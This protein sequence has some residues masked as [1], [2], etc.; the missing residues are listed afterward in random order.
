MDQVERHV[1]EPACY[2]YVRL[3]IH[4]N[5]PAQFTCDCPFIAPSGTSSTKNYVSISTGHRVPFS[6]RQLST[7]F[8]RRK[9]DQ[10]RSLPSM[11]GTTRAN[12][13]IASHTDFLS[14]DD[15]NP[16]LKTECPVCLG[17]IEEHVCVKII[18]IP[19]CS[20]LIGL[21]CL[22]TLLN[23]NPNCRK[24]CPF[25]RTEWLPALF[26]QYGNLDAQTPSN[27][28]RRRREE[29]DREIRRM[30]EESDAAVGWSQEERENRRFLEQEE[31][32]LNVRESSALTG[33]AARGS[34]EQRRERAE[35]VAEMHRLMEDRDPIQEPSREGDQMLEENHET[36][37]NC[38]LGVYIDPY[39]I[40]GAQDGA[41]AGS[42]LFRREPAREDPSLQRCLYPEP[43]NFAFRPS[44]GDNGEAGSS[45]DRQSTASRHHASPSSSPPHRQEPAYWPGHFS[46]SRSIFDTNDGPVLRSN[47]LSDLARIDGPA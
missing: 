14:R 7:D 26:D 20:H 35:Q 37:R 5:Q 18:C 39:E 16:P 3:Y 6:S 47:S 28:V 4:W 15:A 23:D 30:R 46:S 34:Y 9:S 41:M 8:H 29:S 22:E 13:F 10:L 1:N 43:T 45:R 24:T 33:R 25:C 31:R 12:Y 38:Y 32:N 42:A 40:L 21:Q 27:N 2:I 19:G 17:G 11:S 44:S 36:V